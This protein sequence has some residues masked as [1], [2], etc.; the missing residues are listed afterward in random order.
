VSREKNHK[1]T[2]HV[3]WITCH[4]HWI[5][6]NVQRTT[7]NLWNYCVDEMN[8]SLSD[9]FLW[10]WEK[11]VLLLDT[12]FVWY[13][14][15]W[16]LLSFWEIFYLIL[17]SR[18]ISQLIKLVERHLVIELFNHSLKETWRMFAMTKFINIMLN[19]V[20]TKTCRYHHDWW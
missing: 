5:E 10:T 8:C 1:W 19:Y 17:L 18:M 6:D 2:Y 15:V 7:I 12:Y 9:Y 20:L 14:Y 16:D 3:R 11:F 13:H 4:V